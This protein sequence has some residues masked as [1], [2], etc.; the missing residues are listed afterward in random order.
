M[1]RKALAVAASMLTSACFAVISYDTT[2]TVTNPLALTGPE[3]ISVASGVTVTYSGGGVISGAGLLTKTGAGTLVLATANPDFSGGITVQEGAVQMDAEG[4]FGTG[5]LTTTAA[6]TV[7]K[8]T[9]GFIFNA[10]DATVANAVTVTLSAA[11]TDW[12][13]HLQTKKNTTFTG[14]ISSTGTGLVRIGDEV[15][16]TTTVQ[17]AIIGMQ[18]TA[19]KDV[20]FYTRGHLAIKGPI[21]CSILQYYNNSSET[22]PGEV[23]YWTPGSQHNI[24]TGIITK[25]Q[26][27]FCEGENVLPTSGYLSWNS[28]AVRTTTHCFDLQGHDQTISGLS[29]SSGGTYGAGQNGSCIYS[30]GGPATLTLAGNGG[31]TYCQ[32]MDEVSIVVNIPGKTQS[33]KNR[34]CPTTGDLT[35]TAGTATLLDAQTFPNMKHVTVG[36]AGT[37][38]INSTVPGAFAGAEEVTVEGSG[39]LSFASTATSP[40]S[41][42]KTVLR[43]SSTSKVAI[44]NGMTVTVSK[45]Y[46]DGDRMADGTY[47][48]ASWL[49]STGSLVVRNLVVSSGTWTAGAAP[50]DAVS[51]A[52]NWGGTLPDLTGGG[53]NATVAAGSRMTLDTPFSFLSLAFTG[54]VAG[55]AV[56]GNETLTAGGAVSAAGDGTAREWT[57][58]APL[59]LNG[60]TS[61]TFPS[62]DTLKFTGGITGSGA[63]DVSAMAT[64]ISGNN[65]FEGSFSLSGGTLALSGTIGPAGD[66]SEF[67]QTTSADAITFRGDTT[68]NKKIAFR[69]NGSTVLFET[70]VTVTLNGKITFIDQF[71]P[72]LP[73]S[74]HLIVNGELRYDYV[75]YA[76]GSACMGTITFLVAPFFRDSGQVIKPA[77]G[78]HEW[79][80]GRESV[81]PAI[82]YGAYGNATN[83]FGTGCDRIFNI[84][85]V[86]VENKMNG[87]ILFASNNGTCDLNGTTQW[88]NRA[89]GTQGL[90]TSATPA[91]LEIVPIQKTLWEP[92]G[93]FGPRVEGP[94]SIVFGPRTGAESAVMTLTNR[95]FASTGDITVTNGTFVVAANASWLNGTNV[96]V[97]GD[98]LLKL[99]AGTAFNRDFAVIHFADNG[100]IEVPAGVTQTF[101]EGWDGATKLASGKR[102]TAVDLPL[103]VTGEGAIRIA[104]FGTT[105]ILR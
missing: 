72:V 33:F 55:F 74:S 16:V 80:V 85:H 8:K 36:T 69:G 26:N 32:F 39:K 93:F 89:H 65:P 14:G 31:G 21:T 97:K 41:A 5:P 82:F 17:C 87:D 58:A 101:A 76:P 42:E 105:L 44:P 61:W 81:A 90:L 11:S 46:V 83:V 64:E 24:T 56:E 15:G 88:F 66:T 40:F 100:R 79:C 62:T 1:N 77:A 34:T 63:M 47:T 68:I 48:T 49:T 103:R 2:Q 92:A 59:A 37:L 94:I 18:G 50:D 6:S 30:T 9:C 7:N 73:A 19:K 29:W 27:H 95:V 75:S 12:C 43:V 70:N 102:Y 28:V 78:R 10:A 104:P 22:T 96:T 51:K 60:I 4:A 54:D 98:G 20:Y 91:T 67:S 35:V 57:F 71:A 84:A 99:E 45:L 25:N 86:A 23:H 52:A 38:N 13:F 53:L 3:T